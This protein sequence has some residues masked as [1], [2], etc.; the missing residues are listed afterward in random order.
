MTSPST[1]RFSRAA[2]AAFA[3]IAAR[4][5]GSEPIDIEREIA[6]HP[7]IADELRELHAR[8]SRV[9]G[10]LGG[11]AADEATLDSVERALRGPEPLDEA[12]EAELARLAD[13]DRYRRRYERIELV[14]AGGMGE[15]WRVLDRDL[16]RE[17]AL[18]RLK[19]RS[20]DPRLLRRFLAE[21]KLTARLEHPGIVPVHDTGIDDD[22]RVWFTMPLVRGENLARLL[23]RERAR[24]PASRSASAS[25]SASSASGAAPSS[26]RTA[27]PA[28]R[29]GLPEVLECLLKACDAVAY[30]HA[31]GVVHRD[32]KPANVLIGAFGEVYVVDWGLARA[33]EAQSMSKSTPA[34]EARDRA[35]DSA[36]ADETRHGDVLGTPAYMPPEQAAA[37]AG[38]VDPRVDVYALGAILWHALTGR[39]PYAGTSGSDVIEAVLRAG[40]EPLASA[41]PDAPIELAAICDKAMSRDPAARYADVRELSEDLRAFLAGRVVRA[42]RTGAIPELVKWCRRNRAL[43]ATI[44]VATVALLAGAWAWSWQRGRDAAEILRLADVARWQELERRAEELGPASPGSRSAFEAWLR[45]AKDLAA[46]RVQHENALRALREHGSITDGQWIFAKDEDRFRHGLLTQLVDGLERLTDPVHGTQSLVRERF[47]LARSMG[48]ESLVRG[49]AAWENAIAE[50]AREPVYRGLAL[51][52]IVGLVPI[53]RDPTTKLFEFAHLPSGTPPARDATGALVL[54][55]SSALVLV[56][57]PGGRFYLGANSAASARDG[58]GDPWARDDEGPRRQI[59]IAPF[60]AGKHEMS[61]AQWRRIANREDGTVDEASALLPADGM[62]WDDARR[63]LER[64]GL[65]MPTEAQWEYAARGGTTTRWWTGNEAGSLRGAVHGRAALD[66]RFVGAATSAPLAIDTLRANDYGLMHVLGNVAEWTLDP[67]TKDATIGLRERDGGRLSGDAA[68]RAVRGGSWAS[69][70]VDLRSTARAEVHG[71]SSDRK[72][73]VRACRRL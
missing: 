15:V 28:S 12:T 72:I 17:L 34:E 11:L 49:R 27:L 64:V 62:T 51:S 25:D 52:P 30:A 7:E 63:A 59:Q 32:L 36:S 21:A 54:D 50:I 22:G 9:E 40:P 71:H 65:E 68:H 73:G 33:R 20:R 16:G 31:R 67:W 53:G 13:P 41:A 66:P 6:A 39:P 2:R 29:P 43:A 60:L 26:A 46:R 14:A 69:D 37:S 70:A 47:E 38:P 45:D 35:D 3:E 4:A 61:R 55:E 23:N 1:G 24:L 18:K 57:L 5:E 48:E 56:L 58:G 8:W 10:W 42:H 44:A 19:T